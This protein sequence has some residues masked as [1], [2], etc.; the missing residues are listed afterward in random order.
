VARAAEVSP[1]H[2][3]RVLRQRNQKRISRD[4]AGR[5]AS[6][7]DLPKDYFPEYREGQLIQRIRQDPELRDRLYQRYGRDKR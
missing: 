6:A 4:L 2:L 3:S 1:G 5:V 7:L